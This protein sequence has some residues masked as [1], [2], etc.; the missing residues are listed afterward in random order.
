LLRLLEHL[1]GFPHARRIAQ[2]DFQRAS[3]LGQFGG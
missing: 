2:E 3:L 1:V